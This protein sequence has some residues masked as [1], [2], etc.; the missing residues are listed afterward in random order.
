M[1][2]YMVNITLGIG[3]FT[4]VLR[5]VNI[6][7]GGILF[8]LRF[9]LNLFGIVFMSKKRSYSDISSESISDDSTNADSE[10]G[11]GDS[12]S[13]DSDKT[14]T[15]QKD[16]EDDD[17]TPNE[18][19][20]DI[21]DM[22]HTLDKVERLIKGENTN[23]DDLKNIKEEYSSYF[24]YESENGTELESLNQIK[25]YLD[26]ELSLTLNSPSFDALKKALNEVLE[27]SSSKSTKGN[28]QEPVNK[29]VKTSE[30]SS[31]GIESTTEE[32]SS[33]STSGDTSQKIP[34]DGLSPLDYV[35]QKESETPPPPGESGDDPL[36]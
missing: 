10:N 32:S 21:T 28:S 33:S 8:P 9:L 34:S 27:E 1:Y 23:K 6:W 12:D 20:N 24:D 15:N 25:E 31:S 4:I 19:I 36:I 35:I 5:G 13:G 22:K 14:P 18:T 16:S 11:D 26:G 17:V 3:L 29:K 2:I 7:V 30:G